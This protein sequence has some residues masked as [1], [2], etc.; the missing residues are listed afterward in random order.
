MLVA[1]KS[2]YGS[3]GNG[4]LAIFKGNEKPLLW[5]KRII[6]IQEI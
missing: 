2:I 4:L 1:L 5:Q 3:K 6:L